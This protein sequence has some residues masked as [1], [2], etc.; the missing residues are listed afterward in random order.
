M[1]ERRSA[2][3]AHPHAKPGERIGL[4]TTGPAAVTLGEWRPVNILQIS[5][6]AA[7]IEAAGTQLAETLGIALP[8]PNRWSGEPHR[9]LRAVA[10]GVW[11]AVGVEWA[12][13]DAASLRARLAEAATVVD[14][15]HARTALRISGSA[16]TRALNQH[17]GLDLSDAQFPAG[18]ATN[19]RFGHIGMTLARLD[20]KPTLEVLVFRGYAEFVFDALIDG[21][22]EFGVVI[23][24]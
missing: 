12:L 17:C 24:E 16:A 6:F 10:P 15:S 5:A 7:S 9:N 2:L 1:L 14:L 3:A 4:A 19:T 21:A 23:G 13:P 20:D 22:R 11:L 8:A 18:S